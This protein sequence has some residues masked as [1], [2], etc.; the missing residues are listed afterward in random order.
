MTLLFLILIPT[1]KSAVNLDI[2]QLEILRLLDLFAELL[3]ELER[4]V[5]RL[6]VLH[7]VVALLARHTPA[8]ARRGYELF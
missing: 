5:R 1:N 4:L 8:R 7:L 6:H 3:A 2:S